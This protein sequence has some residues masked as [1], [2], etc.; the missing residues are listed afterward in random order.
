M[1]GTEFNDFVVICYNIHSLMK[2]EERIDWL[3]E[4]LGNQRWDL[5]VFSETWR[6][7]RVEVMRTQHGHTWLGSGGANIKGASAFYCTAVGSICGSSPYRTGLV[8]STC[9]YAGDWF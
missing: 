3:L 6:A 7:E 9:V 1:H 4:E 8:S 2:F 5:I